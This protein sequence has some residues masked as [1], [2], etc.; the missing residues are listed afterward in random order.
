MFRTPRFVALLPV[1]D[2][3]DVI[4]ECL[5]HAQAW[6][7]RIYVYDTGSV[8]DTYDIVEDMAKSD[9]RIRPIGREPVYFN[10]NRVRG[11]LF[12][13]A[14]AELRT[15]DWFLRMDADEFHHVAPPE[16]VATRLRPGEGVVYHQ[17]YDFHLT[18][19]EADGLATP[20]AIDA[21]R[22]RPIA[23]RRR[24]YTVSVYAEPRMC[25]YRASMRWPEAVS[26]PYN[27]GLVARERLP[28]RHYPHRDPRQLD[29]RCR[30][31]AVMLAD[32]E[33][34]KHWS[35]PDQ[36]HWSV[37]DWRAFVSAEDAPG[38]ARWDP[39]TP[40]PE[41]RQTNHLATG[42]RRLAQR[43][44]YALGAQLLLDLTR[45]AWTAEAHPRPIA[46]ETQAVLTQ[47]LS[48]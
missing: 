45:A 41:V 46:P 14:R 21:E 37:G 1:R 8:D 40:L 48:E 27:A 9:D 13:T 29:R 30:L 12:E 25:R 16:F 33:N 38:L 23:E 18:Q 5:S 36:M 6:A 28:I 32:A 47:E 39:S 35:N 26:F 42:G 3:G 10:E 34:R 4:R 22:R 15:G 19:S 20:E 17:Y 7:D 2:E 44:L 43:A 24:A 31:R 11:L